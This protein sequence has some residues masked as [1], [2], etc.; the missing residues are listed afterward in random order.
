MFSRD[1]GRPEGA[2]S[3]HIFENV[4]QDARAL[5]ACFCLPLVQMVGA[6]LAILLTLAKMDKIPPLGRFP[7]LCLVGGLQICPYFAI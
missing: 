3:K 6:A 1:F 2:K 4:A 5:A 7:A